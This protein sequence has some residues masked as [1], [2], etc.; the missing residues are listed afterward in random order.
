MQHSWDIPPY[1]D[2]NVHLVRVENGVQLSVGSLR[3]TLPVERSP[4]VGMVGA[5][6]V[7]PSLLDRTQ[8]LTELRFHFQSGVFLGKL[9]AS[10]GEQ[11][12]HGFPHQ[13]AIAVFVQ[14][15][16]REV[17]V[18]FEFLEELKGLCGEN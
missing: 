9:T 6:F 14:G 16:P 2:A 17:V 12:P 15:H 10:L 7:G 18:G 8:D 11:G 3:S 5:L 1:A 13:I 4:V